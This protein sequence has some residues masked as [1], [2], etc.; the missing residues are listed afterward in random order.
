MLLY[1]ISMVYGATGSLELS[2]VSAVAAQ[3]GAED[4]VLVFGLVFLVV[5]VAFKFGA[6]PFHMWI[7]D[8]YQGAPTPVTLMIGTAPKLAAFAMTMRL[9]V[10]G[11]G[12][13]HADW[14]QMLIV[15]S[16]LSM[17]VGNL[18]AIAQ[19]NIKRMLAYSTIANVGFILLGILAGTAEGESRSKAT[20]AYRHSDSSSRP[21]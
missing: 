9:L 8:V 1:G 17:A 21:R 18:I 10:D 12:S 2:T 14:Q 4:L 6:V 20:R 5:G 16:V 11:M 15:L 13:L 3:R 7:P 19:T